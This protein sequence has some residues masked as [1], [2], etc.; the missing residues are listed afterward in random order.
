VGVF[1][2]VLGVVLL[3][4]VAALV[5]ADRALNSASGEAAAIDALETSRLIE[6]LLLAQIVSLTNLRAPLAST[7]GSRRD[8][9]ERLANEYAR[10]TPGLREL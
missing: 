4:M 9:L 2:T 6:Q 7:A 8:D 3:L 1:S 5:T 10:G